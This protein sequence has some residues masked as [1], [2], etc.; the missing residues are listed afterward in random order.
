MTGDPKDV[1]KEET[2]PEDLQFKLLLK[3]ARRGKGC[4]LGFGWGIGGLYQAEVRVALKKMGR[5]KAVGS[6]Q[7]PMD[8]WKCLGDERIKWLTCLFNKIFQSAKMSDEW[9]L[10]EVIPI[11]KNKE[12][13]EKGDGVS[14]NQFGFM[15]GRSTIEAILLLRSLMEKLDEESK[16]LVYVIPDS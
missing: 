12:K 5:N 1:E 9:R 7:I 2:L 11:Y 6:D 13:V 10:G 8:A 4:M 16:R 15:P 3:V 14:E